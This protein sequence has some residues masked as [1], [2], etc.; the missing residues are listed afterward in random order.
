MRT[1]LVF[2]LLVSSLV[3]LPVLAEDHAIGVRAGLLGI[4]VDYS[5]R[6]TDRIAVR[7]GLNGSSYSFSD[8]ESGIDYAFSLD[9]DSVSVGVDIHPLKGKF[10]VSTGFLQNDSGLS[11]RSQ[12][13]QT[14]DIG[15]TVYQA[16]DVGTLS[17]RIGFDSTAPF[18]SVGFDWLHDKKVG[19][20]FDLG[21]LSQG[22]PKVS[23][24]ANGP[25][26]SD[27]GFIADL[28]A[29]RVDLQL[30]LDDLDL[31]PFAAFGIV[32]RF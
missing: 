8:T 25:I 9:F 16:V 24:S 15:G 21:L 6:L 3:A 5:Y 30:E 32:V 1:H 26:A 28:E 18:L 7:G 29:E 23:L 19:V 4:G 11:A 12:V 17:G 22:A 20:A 2:T 10:R 31:Y 27:P 14:F 13:A